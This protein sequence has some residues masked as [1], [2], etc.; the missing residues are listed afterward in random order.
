VLGLGG[1]GGA[2]LIVQIVVVEALCKV[3]NRKLLKHLQGLVLLHGILY[4][5]LTTI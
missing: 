2:A 4:S 5:Q 3:Y 1:E